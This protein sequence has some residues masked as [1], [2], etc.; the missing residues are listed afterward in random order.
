MT[1]AAFACVLACLPVVALADDPKPDVAKLKDEVEVLEA[2]LD[3]WKAKLAGAEELAVISKDFLTRL[4][5][6]EQKGAASMSDMITMMQSHTRAN[7]D[8]NVARA[9]VKVAEVML[10]QAKRRLAMAE[11]SV[12]PAK[13]EK[14]YS[15]RFENKPWADVLEWFAKESG[16]VNASKVKPT[17]T[18]TIKAP[19]GKHYTMTE[20]VDLLNESMAPKFILVRA[21]QTF[22]LLPADE[23][24][25]GSY[26]RRIE[27]K[28]LEKCG[29][30]ELVSVFLSLGLLNADDTIPQLKVMLSSFGSIMPLGKNGIIIGDKAK[31]VKRIVD[32]V[33]NIPAETVKRK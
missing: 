28:D 29:R 23:M 14:L 30:T 32:E 25:D 33:A 6:A 22:A 12:A 8:V 9:E 5:E 15:I 1:R 16:L 26:F 2:K 31:H 13:P 3:I 10:N 20:I 21:K 18:V 24:A 17:G 27:L 19:E 4:K 11:K 7:T